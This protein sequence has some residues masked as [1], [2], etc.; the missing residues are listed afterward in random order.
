MFVGVTDADGMAATWL[1]ALRRGDSVVV[2]STAHGLS[3][4]QFKS[5]VVS[6]AGTLVNPRRGNHPTSVP[7]SLSELRDALNRILHA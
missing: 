1:A 4:T 7:A 5:D 3:F 6:G 2:I